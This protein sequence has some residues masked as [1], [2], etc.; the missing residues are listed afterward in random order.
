MSSIQSL[1]AG[2]QFIKLKKI[3]KLNYAG[4]RV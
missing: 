1:N 3:E 2:Y 4:K